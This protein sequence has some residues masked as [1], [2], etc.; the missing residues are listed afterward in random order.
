MTPDDIDSID[1]RIRVVCEQDDRLR[2]ERARKDGADGVM[3]TAAVAYTPPEEEPRSGGRESVR[4]FKTRSHPC[5]K[6]SPRCARRLPS[7]AA[8]P[9]RFAALADLSGGLSCGAIIARGEHI[10]ASTSSA[11]TVAGM[12]QSAMTPAFAPVKTGCAV[13]SASLEIRDRAASVG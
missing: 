10:I 9:T 12:S 13:R 7:C 6:R 11:S 5:G 3:Q 8:L 1:A 4:K 2:A